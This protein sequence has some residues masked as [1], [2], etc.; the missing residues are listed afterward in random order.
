MNIYYGQ[1]SKIRTS[2]AEVLKGWWCPVKNYGASHW[3]TTSQTPI[4]TPWHWTVQMDN[5]KEIPTSIFQ[6]VKLHYTMYKHSWKTHTRS[7]EQR[8]WT[9][10]YLTNHKISSYGRRFSK[11]NPRG[12]KTSDAENISP[13]YSSTIIMSP[14]PPLSLKKHKKD[15]RDDK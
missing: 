12:S 11:K 10:N 15:T 7:H 8:L 13:G 5:N 6:Q 1:K 9:P 14:N 4:L 2:E 3:R